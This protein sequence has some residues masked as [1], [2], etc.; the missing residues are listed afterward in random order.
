[1][2][3]PLWLDTGRVLE[4]WHTGHDDAADSGQFLRVAL[5]VRRDQPGRCRCVDHIGDRVRSRD[6][7]RLDR[8]DGLDDGRGKCPKGHVFVPFFDETKRINQLTLEKFDAFSK[9]PDYKK[10]AVKITK[11]SA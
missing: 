8:T 7:P 10:C 3:Y 6:S 4:H 5:G 2:A 9:Q 11:V 1:M